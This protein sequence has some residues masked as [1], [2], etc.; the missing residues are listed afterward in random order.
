MPK[1]KV[2]VADG[3]APEEPKRRSARLS[4][5]PAPAKAEPKPKK[6]AA[7]KETFPQFI[8]GNI[9]MQTKYMTNS[10]HLRILSRTPCTRPLWECCCN[11]NM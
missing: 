7:K 3:E 8:A 9:F 5:K 6:L 11:V 2:T 1:R 4:A 10:C